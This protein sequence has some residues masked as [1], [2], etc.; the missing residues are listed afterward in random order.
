MT[1][2]NAALTDWSAEEVGSYLA[3]GNEQFFS[4][5]DAV[6]H[7]RVARLVREV[8]EGG[9]PYALGM[10]VRG[11]HE[12]TDLLVVTHDRKALFAQIAGAISMVRGNIVGAKVFTLKNGIAVEQFLVQDL[13][14]NAL[15]NKSKWKEFEGILKAWIA[16]DAEIPQVELP[17]KRPSRYDIFHV[18]P[19]VI[20]EN[21]IS[22]HHTVVEVNGHDRLGF[23]FTI[24]RALAELEL[25]I[26]TA[27]ISSYGE[28]AVD[29]FYVKD[30]FGMKVVSEGKLKQ[31]RDHL[32]QT[33]A[34][35][36]GASTQK[37]PA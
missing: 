30:K 8:E 22:S 2:L 27:H 5:V 18:P 25:S 6:T 20:V 13:H 1:T 19:R 10:E 36:A 4:G 37:K 12:H 21:H 31:I 9:K 11:Q 14:G 26:S 24:T 7:A 32:T 28:R 23:L 15:E 16:S 17:V 3:L 35:A 33:L 34:E 29:V